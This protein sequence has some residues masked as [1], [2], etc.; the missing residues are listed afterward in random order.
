MAVK[1]VKC[2]VVGDG[3]VG[4]TCLQMSYTSGAFPEEYIPTV[5][6]IDASNVM[7]DGQVV[8]L[9]LW[10]TA[11]QEEY[12]TLRPLSYPQTDVFLICFSLDNPTSYKN[13][14][15]KWFEEV[16]EN[17]PNTPIILVGTKLDLRD[18]TQTIEKLN[19]ENKSPITYQ[20][21]LT[22]AERIDAVK[23]MECSA[24]TQKG[25]TLVFDEAI[26]A[27]FTLPLGH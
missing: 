18:D 2:M 8:N 3:T 5:C 12:D 21:G 20:Q 17:C 1:S 10:D 7:V 23:Y 11:G 27:T 6:D 4:K 24:L 15:T 22:L 9:S 19:K 13:A 16:K 14:E 25:L 26:R